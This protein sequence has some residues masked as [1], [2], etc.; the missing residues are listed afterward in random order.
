ME[1]NYSFAP[2][3]QGSYVKV[4]PAAM[5]QRNRHI[6]LHWAGRTEGAPQSELS[7][8]WH[9]S[10]SI[11]WHLK[12]SLNKDDLEI[13]KVV[14]KSFELIISSLPRS[15]AQIWLPS[16]PRW[17]LPATLCITGRF[18]LG[19]GLF[20]NLPSPVTTPWLHR[21]PISKYLSIHIKLNWNYHAQ[22]RILKI[23]ENEFDFRPLTIVK[24]KTKQK[25]V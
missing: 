3:P 2:W 13:C 17:S 9:K 14:L 22:T 8:I 10:V 7:C 21:S 12:S 6:A 23:L 18:D 19:G 20:G 25:L 4:A 16:L 5:C 11:L 15:L 24:I 1:C